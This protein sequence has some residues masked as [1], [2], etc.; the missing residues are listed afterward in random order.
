MNTKI[1][2]VP[3]YYSDIVRQYLNQ[4]ANV[5]DI[6]TGGGEMFLCFASNFGK[7]VGIDI[8]PD[9][10]RQAN[11][12]KK[13]QEI[14][15]VEFFVMDSNSLEFKDLHF[16]VVFNR[17]SKVNTS[18]IARVM[19]TGGYF[20]TQQ[21]A[22]RNT[23]NI[24]NAFGGD[25]EKI[26]SDVGQPVERVAEEFEEKGFSV[27]VKNDYDVPYWFC[28]LESFVFWL[29]AVPL[30]EPFDVEKH[31][32]CVNQIIEKHSTERGIE[33]N[34]HRELLIVQKQ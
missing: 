5:L 29:K 30:P 1:A 19:C 2:P 7:G 10:I 11:Q 32:N 31:L 23:I 21:V 8:M 17:H 27:V 22:S 4:T 28:D 18:E 25:S 6:G 14:N 33:T 34:E 3:W 15:N 20:I 26:N 9:M 24:L 13:K 16:D 12:N